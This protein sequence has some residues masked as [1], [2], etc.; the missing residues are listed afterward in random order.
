MNRRTLLLGLIALPATAR[1]HSYTHGSIAVGHAWGAGEWWLALELPS[2][3]QDPLLSNDG[4]DFALWYAGQRAW[5]AR[6]TAYGL[7]GLVIPAP[8]GLFAGRLKDYYLFGQ[9]GL[10][11]RFD[12][13]W[14]VFVQAD[15]HTAIVDNANVDG[16]DH[17]LQGQFGLRL[18]ALMRHYRLDLF[19][20]EDILPGHAPD[21]TFSLRVS[22]K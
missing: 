18:P 17:S 22:P 16:L 14:H 13:A 4:I 5:H 10:T 3:E 9:F 7:A 8:K 12:A 1:A 19:F 2:S 15:M 20:S 6:S 11:Y 21:I